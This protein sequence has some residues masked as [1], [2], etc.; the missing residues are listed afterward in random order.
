VLQLELKEYPSP[1]NKEDASQGAQATAQ[2]QAQEAK[3][4]LQ[5]LT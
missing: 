5:V 2:N 4:L 3:K 1:G